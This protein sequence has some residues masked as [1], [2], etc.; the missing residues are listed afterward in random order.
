MAIQGASGGPLEY[1]AA[2]HGR[3]GS[4]AITQVDSANY[5]SCLLA[6][7][8]N[9]LRWPCRGMLGQPSAGMSLEESVP[10]THVRLRGSF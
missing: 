9:A 8:A 3:C 2:N 6:A 7:L 1:L 4:S 5:S 10:A